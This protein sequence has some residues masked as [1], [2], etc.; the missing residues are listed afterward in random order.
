VA[1]DRA[2]PLAG[3]RACSIGPACPCCTRRAG[4][5]TDRPSDL[6]GPD[7]AGPVDDQPPCQKPSRILWLRLQRV[8]CTS[9]PQ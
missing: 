6:A 9:S 3:G 8:Y 2:V 5:R 7:A 1:G 4:W